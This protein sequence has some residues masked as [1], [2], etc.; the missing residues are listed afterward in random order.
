MRRRELVAGL[1]GGGL[2]L[3]GGAVALTD[4]PSLFDDDLPE[5][6]DPIEIEAIEA[7]GSEAGTRTVPDDEEATVLTFFAT[8]CE[9]CAEKMPNLAEAATT[10][11]AE[12][13]NFVSV[14]AEP[15]GDNVPESAVVEWFEDHGG[16]WT[17]AHDSGSELSVAYDGIPYPKTAVVD[18]A[19]RVWWEHTGTATTDELV[20]GIEGAL[21]DAAEHTDA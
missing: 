20:S 2:L 21:E 12:P 3:G 15:V 5:G 8:T 1:L 14:T 6:N 9:S 4:G 11:E 16:D 13:I 18:T 7:R 10:L 17:V 19:G